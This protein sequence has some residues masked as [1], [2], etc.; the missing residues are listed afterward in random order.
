MRRPMPVDCTRRVAASQCGQRS[1]W[2][3]IQKNTSVAA[4]M[5]RT[6]NPPKISTKITASDD[7][8][9]LPP[10]SSPAYGLRDNVQ[11]RAVN[12]NGSRQVE[13]RA[14]S[15]QYEVIGDR[16]RRR[17]TTAAVTTGH[18]AALTAAWCPALFGG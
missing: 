15:R 3:R 11:R 7:M 17:E 8:A 14:V 12:A 2:G 18:H 10:C 13:P 1:P 6:K 5:R 4:M 9:H 16:R